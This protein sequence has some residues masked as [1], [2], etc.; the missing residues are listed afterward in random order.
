MVLFEVK[1]YETSSAK[2]V[3][4]EPRNHNVIVF[5][6]AYLS[7]ASYRVGPDRELKVTV[8]YSLLQLSPPNHAFE[9]ERTFLYKEEVQEEL[10]Y[11]HNLFIRRY[12]AIQ[13]PHKVD[14]MKRRKKIFCVRYINKTLIRIKS[15]AVVLGKWQDLP[16]I[17]GYQAGYGTTRPSIDLIH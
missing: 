9:A 6:S 17:E 1:K 2:D 10:V 12:S 13:H 11:L 14:V 15:N 4:M 5:L 8:S 16:V 3:D 7:V